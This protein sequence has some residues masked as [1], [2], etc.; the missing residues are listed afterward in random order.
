[1]PRILVIDDDRGIREV[2]CLLLKERGYDVEIAGD[3]EQAI[4]LLAMSTGFD[5]VITDIRMPVTDGN[6]VARYVRTSLEQD[7]SLVAMTGFSDEIEKGLF[8]YSIEKPFRLEALY[9]IIQSL[10]QKNVRHE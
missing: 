2:L 5:L 1:V 7:V 4:E 8:D 9:K 3:G 6:E 10:G